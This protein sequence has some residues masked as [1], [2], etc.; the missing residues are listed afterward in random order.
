MSVIYDYSKLRGRLI[1]KYGTVARFSQFLDVSKSTVSLKLNNKVDISRD[2]IIKWSK[3][4]EI[5][6]SDY[7]A[8]YFVQKLNEV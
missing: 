8:F 5:S 3:I 2:D 6:P 4:L 7:G 1:E